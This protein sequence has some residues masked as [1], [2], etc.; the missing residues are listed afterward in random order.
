[1]GALNAICHGNRIETMRSG[2]IL[3]TGDDHPSRR[4]KVRDGHSHEAIDLDFPFLTIAE[5][6]TI[7]AIEL[8][9]GR[10]GVIGYTP[11]GESSDRAFS[12]ME[13]RDEVATAGGASARMTLLHKPGIA[14]PV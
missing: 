12:I 11:F 5:L 4:F 10:T 1:M 7:R 9:A 13:Y 3:A 14:V 8:A 6:T 2:R